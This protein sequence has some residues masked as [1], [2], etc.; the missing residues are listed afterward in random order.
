L[1]P[2][3][4]KG[5]DNEDDQTSRLRI[6][7]SRLLTPFASRGVGLLGFAERDPRIV[8]KKEGF[9]YF[10]EMMSSIRDKVTDLILRAR[11]VGRAEAR[12]NYRGLRRV[13]EPRSDI[14]LCQR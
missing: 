7:R 6:V 8:Y 12:S 2:R 5:K 11:V 9:R 14:Q 13:G 3:P 4:R 10:E 1:P